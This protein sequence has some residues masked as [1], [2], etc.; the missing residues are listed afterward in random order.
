M[1]YVDS[2]TNHRSAWNKGILVGSKLPLKP[3]DIWAIRIRLSSRIGI[4]T[5]PFSI[6]QSIASCE[7]VP[8]RFVADR[9][10]SATCRF[11]VCGHALRRLP[12]TL[13]PP[14]L[15][16]SR[17]WQRLPSGSTKLATVPQS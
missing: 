15:D 9:R 6:S 10:G 11:V 13:S 7:A 16:S 5:S 12:D 2:T 8:G 1:N 14:K 17:S 4:G 3:K